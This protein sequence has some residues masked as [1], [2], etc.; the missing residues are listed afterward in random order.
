MHK[1]I[2]G[3]GLGAL[4]CSLGGCAVPPVQ[5]TQANAPIQVTGDAKS[6]AIQFKKI[7]INIPAG[8]DIG[9]AMNGIACEI[10]HQVTWHGSGSMDVSD[11]SFTD[12]FRQEL[13]KANYQVVG[14]PDA[15]FDD[16]NTW[17]AEYLVAGAIS[18]L[19]I[20]ACYIAGGYKGGVY[21]KVDWQVYSRLDR[22]VVYQVSTEGS[23][24]TPNTVDD[25]D[26]VM[27]PAFSQATDNLLA[28]QKFHD[29]I[30]TA[31]PTL[32]A[33]PAEAVTMAGKKEYGTPL[34]KHVND[35]RAAVMTVYA[36]DGSGTAVVIA[37]GYALTDSHVVEKAKFVKLKLVT[38]RE[39]L[40]EVLRSD[41]RRD[42]AL[43]K[44]EDDS[45]PA[46][47]VRATEANVGEDVYA[48]GSSLGT[49]ESTLSK[50]IL[51]A[52]RTQDG[53]RYIQ[54]DVT[55]LPG[56][57]GGPL[58]DHDGN[59]IGLTEMGIELSGAPAGVNFFNP[60]LDCLKALNVQ[61]KPAT[62]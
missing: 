59:L 12:I 8:T 54:S 45:I 40:G 15:L 21:M 52:Y 13:T 49:F 3:L 19:Q 58:F 60:I 23:Y 16:P 38:G 22:K 57:S 28:D 48:L 26:L 20:N 11:K 24:N 46:V 30:V 10:R 36:G 4:L 55:V 53:M 27:R 50:G 37:P 7:V 32:A 9:T 34:P 2:K 56:N 61:F 44:I 33:P 5:M 1:A 43:L 31:E 6:K 18:R 51:S 41:T 39:M 42:V 62:K 17:Q 14:D 25:L 35:V 29:L 47:P